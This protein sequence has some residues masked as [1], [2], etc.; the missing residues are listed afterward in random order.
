[1]HSL[2]HIQHEYMIQSKIYSCHQNPRYGRMQQCCSTLRYR[3]ATKPV[4]SHEH[5]DKRNV[6]NAQS[7]TIQRCAC[8]LAQGW[9]VFTCMQWAAFVP[10]LLV[11]T[12]HCH[13]H[14][15]IHPFCQLHTNS[16]LDNSQRHGQVARNIKVARWSQYYKMCI[17]LNM[18]YCL[19][20]VI[21]ISSFQ[22]WRALQLCSVH[23]LP[24]YM[25]SNVSSILMIL[26]LPHGILLWHTAVYRELCSTSI[27][28]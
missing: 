18:V 11:H 24:N 17:K 15:T 2:L 25:S 6:F 10:Y 28:M 9:E 5:H 1:M 13:G 23:S 27:I 4:N 12:T 19:L 20:R 22:H 21:F 16:C 14:S 7:V 26:V 8:I 3:A